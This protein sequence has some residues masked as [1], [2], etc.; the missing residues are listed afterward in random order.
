MGKHFT[1]KELTASSVAKKNGISN[2]PNKSE[3]ENLVNLI[4]NILDPLREAYGNPIIINSGFRC[5]ECKG[6]KKYTF[7]DVRKIV[8][9]KNCKLMSSENEYNNAH[10]YIK[11]E[12]DKG[13]VYETKFS[14]FLRG[15]GCPY[16]SNLKVD[17]FYVRETIE[18][19]GYTLV[20]DVY[21]NNREKLD[22]KCPNGH[23]FKMSYN[24]FQYG[25][26]CPI[27]R[28][29]NG[30]Q[31]IA[32]NLENRNIK[33]IPQH[34]FSDCKN[35]KTLPFDFYIPSKNICI[36][37]DGIQHFEPVEFFGG[38]EGYNKTKMNDN[39]KNDYCREN[40]IRLIRIPYYEFDNIENILIKEI[41]I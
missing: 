32:K 24:K 31:S 29:S 26:R 41:N 2:I 28:S 40:N 38:K 4:D 16:C 22:V 6:L 10:S 7:E 35:N 21:R 30:E 39:L 1:L 18:K 27:C 34:R 37:Y 3:E 20:S 5:K 23:L 11:L 14:V 9:N 33:Y 13:H 36:E 15:F 19:E 12:C 17:Y 8:T 25:C